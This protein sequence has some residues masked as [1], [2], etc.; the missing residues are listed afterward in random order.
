MPD[1]TPLDDRPAARGLR[2]PLQ[3]QWALEEAD[4]CVLCGLCLPHCPTYRKTGDENE[5]P[6]GRVSLIRALASGALPASE[7]LAA[8]LSLCLGCRACERVCPSGVHYG[9]LIEAGRALVRTQQPAAWL[10][11]I[12]LGLGARPRLLGV[13]GAVLRVYQHSGLQRL[14]RASGVLRLLRAQRLES[15]LPTLPAR[16]PGQA[17]HPALGT[18]RG[19]VALFLGCVARV[20][21][22]DTLAAAIRLLTRLGF[23]VVIPHNQTCCGALQREAGQAGQA[24]EL[25]R[26]NRTAFRAAGVDAVITVAS[27]CGAVLAESGSSDDTGTPH[28]LRILDIHQFLAEVALPESL[29]LAPLPVTIAVQDAC[30]LRNALRAEQAVYALL[31]RI[32]AARIVPLAENHL[33]C[34][35]AGAYPLRQPAMAELLRADKLAH[36]QQLQPTVLATANLGCALH[37]SAGLRAQGMNI[38]VAHPLVLFERQLRLKPA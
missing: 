6:R 29:T 14:V 19:R 7:R 18:R 9:Q 26:Q 24:Q 4:R 2:F 10:T 23:D 38:E 11:R 1:S 35:G 5:S 16:L 3:A 21:D 33:C 12:G 34:G 37:L 30:S 17:S 25:A 22:A 28:R 27:G 36:L 32:P 31:G 15:L 8:H 20:L 13:I